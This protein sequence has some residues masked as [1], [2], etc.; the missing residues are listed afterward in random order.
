M[1]LHYNTCALRSSDLLNLVLV[2]QV[3]EQ[4]LSR[5]LT[6]KTLSTRGDSVTSPMNINQAND[7]KDAFIKVGTF[8][9]CCGLN[10]LLP[11]LNEKK[12]DVLAL[13]S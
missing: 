10:W 13:Y 5:A 12:Y 7:V 9:S 11:Q 1:K 4:A 2:F 6:E 3:N 8:S